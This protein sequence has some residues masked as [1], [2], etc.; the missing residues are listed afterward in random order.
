LEISGLFKLLKIFTKNGLEISLEIIS[1]FW[2]KKPYLWVKK[3]YF[4]AKK[5]GKVQKQ[6]F[7]NIRIYGKFRICSIPNFPK[8]TKK[9]TLKSNFGNCEKLVPT[10][11]PT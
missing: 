7:P 9:W 6:G 5:F 1:C 4:W 8:I 2:V 10:Q 3:T 11:K